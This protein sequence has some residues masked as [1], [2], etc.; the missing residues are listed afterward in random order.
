MIP[1]WTQQ[2]KAQQNNFT[3]YVVHLWYQLITCSFLQVIVQSVHLDDLG[4]LR[5]DCVHKRNID[6]KSFDL[7]WYYTLPKI[8][9]I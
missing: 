2:S 8:S 3:R 7:I 6:D 9:V 1:L 4:K 5:Y